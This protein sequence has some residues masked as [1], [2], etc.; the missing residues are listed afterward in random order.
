MIGILCGFNM[1]N[2]FAAALLH[3]MKRIPKSDLMDILLFSAP[4]INLTDHTAF[5]SILSNGS[6][7]QMKTDIPALIFNCSLRHRRSDVKKLRELTA[8]EHTVILN[9]ANVFSQ[10][11][12]MQMLSSDHKAKDWIFP[13]SLYNKQSQPVTL[14]NMSSFI[15]KPENGVNLAKMTYVK[16]AEPLFHIYNMLGGP[17][18]R[19]SDL[20]QG[21]RTI[22]RD[23]HWLLLET[24]ELLTDKNRMIVMR[25]FLQINHDQSWQVTLQT[26]L[27]QSGATEKIHAADLNP[28]LLKIAQTVHCYIPDLYLCL[29]DF[30]FTPDG[31][32]Y[33]LSF[34]GW[35]DCLLSK[36]H[37]SPAQERL[38]KSI[39]EYAKQYFANEGL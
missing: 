13:Y 30:V 16:R 32:P 4:N 6:I 35:Q 34:G 25:S 38:C 33:F 36:N 14:S 20:N 31:T 19:V 17:Y 27:F 1:E 26:C 15:L 24:P 21:L 22:V 28:K 29:I 10:Y 12:V 3:S 11:A 37:S 5:G 39:L 2:D 9:A 23:R 8:G 18:Y 7:R